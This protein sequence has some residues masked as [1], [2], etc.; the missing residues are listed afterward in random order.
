VKII[1]LFSVDNFFVVAGKKFNIFLSL[2]DRYLSN[3]ENLRTISI[4]L[5]MLA[6]VLF[7][8]LIAFIYIKSMSALLKS[9]QN[10]SQ[11]D[12]YGYNT[13]I[14]QNL[15]KEEIER[16]R[17][18]EL[19]KEL[20]RELEKAVAEQ[21][22]REEKERIIAEQKRKQKEEEQVLAIEE[23]MPELKKRMVKN[24]KENVLDLDWKKGKLKNMETLPEP[25]DMPLQYQQNKKQL[26]ELLGLV[27]DMLGRNVDDLKIAQTIMF[28]NMYQES[29]EAILQTIDAVKDFIALCLNGKFAPLHKE[30][31]LPKEEKALHNL[32]MGD[33]SL[34]LALIEA[35]MD[36]NINK[37]SS[38]QAG[39]K[40][41]KLFALTSNYA[42]IFGSLAA[43]NDIHLATGAFELAIELYP[44][45]I[46]AWNRIGD[47]YKL[48][49]NETQAFKA[50]QNVLTLADEDINTRQSANAEKML[51]QFYYAKGDSLQAAKYYNQSKGYY[52]SIGIN[53]RLDRQEVEI[54]EIIESHQESDLKETIN[55][56]LSN[57]NLKQYSFA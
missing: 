14:T 29:E 7:L 34:A 49:E 23:K 51:S 5:M 35:L 47:M 6:I 3:S 17:Q 1:N 11:R 43:V 48:A 46:N 12:E 27:I 15:N 45:N 26:S 56:I 18:E 9:S 21:A 20:A 2:I 38:M 52:D 37:A 57:K 28:R 39:N 32:A 54:V 30:K 42:Q 50:Y 8:I 55:K 22:A 13:L 40:R 44:Q 53:R 36:E 10:K 24:K 31:A 25:P 16:I 4:V 41:D 33:S 19:E